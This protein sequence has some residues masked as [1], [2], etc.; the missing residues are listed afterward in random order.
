MVERPEVQDI[1]V[2]KKVPKVSYKYVDVPETHYVDKEVV[3]EVE[4]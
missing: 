2:E 1:I 4:V 3:R